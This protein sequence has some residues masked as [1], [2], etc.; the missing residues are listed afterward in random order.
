MALERNR[1]FE[2]GLNGNGACLHASLYKHRRNNL[3]MPFSRLFKEKF[4][5]TPSEISG[6]GYRRESVW[7]RE[8]VEQAIAATNFSEWMRTFVS[9]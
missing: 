8:S 2:L 5:V 3:T 1:R 9:L 4:G 7:P 6:R